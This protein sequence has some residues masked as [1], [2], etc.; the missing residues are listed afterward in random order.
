MALDFY[1]QADTLLEADEARYRAY[2]MLEPPPLLAQM[3]VRAYT[4]L[5][6]WV[7][8]CEAEQL[9]VRSFFD[10]TLLPSTAIPRA[11]LLLEQTYRS[12]TG[13]TLVGS[14]PTRSHN[15]FRQMDAIL[16]HA[17]VGYGIL[18]LCD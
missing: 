17:R 14:D 16:G 6:P 10:D 3:D 15:P 7:Q 13:R 12:M 1:L 5:T 11:R 8:R 18:A 2:F 4:L 9:G